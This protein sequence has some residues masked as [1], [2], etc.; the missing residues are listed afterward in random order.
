ML[1]EFWRE[2]MQNNLF[3]AFQC[4]CTVPFALLLVKGTIVSTALVAGLG[5]EGSSFAYS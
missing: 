1:E 2:T 5:V 3:S 4:A